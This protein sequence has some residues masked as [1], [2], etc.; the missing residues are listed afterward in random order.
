[1]PGC[2]CGCGAGTARAGTCT[3]TGHRRPPRVLRAGEHRGA[4]A[5]VS[6]YPALGEVPTEEPPGLRTLGRVPFDRPPGAERPTWKGPSLGR[7]PFDVWP[8]GRTRP[9]PELGAPPF[10]RLATGLWRGPTLA[11]PG[12]EGVPFGFREGP[13]LDSPPFDEFPHWFTVGRAARKPGQA[14]DPSLAF[15]QLVPAQA[16]NSGCFDFERCASPFVGTPDSPTWFRLTESEWSAKFGPLDIIGGGGTA[17]QEFVRAAWGL[18]HLNTDIVRWVGCM[19]KP[20]VSGFADCMV[21]AIGTNRRPTI[22]LSRTRAAGDVPRRCATHACGFGDT[23]Y[24]VT[25]DP[26]AAPFI[27]LWNGATT[28]GGKVCAAITLARL[29]IHE[30][31]HAVCGQFH[32]RGGVAWQCDASGLVGNASQ[33]CLAHRYRLWIEPC[34]ACFALLGND[35]VFA[36]PGAARRPLATWPC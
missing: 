35:R 12:F 7:P 21:Q 13:G 4:A 1:M 26:G 33:W 14:T 18:M 3:A 30:L 16:V 23:I 8:E 29:L 20:A 24:I 19:I 28:T 27:N 11:P 34:G 6:D 2:G 25:D 31:A 5:S 15:V 22:D 10:D 17:W 36:N 9:T 32:R